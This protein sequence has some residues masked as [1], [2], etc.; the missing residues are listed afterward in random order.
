M[1]DDRNDKI[2]YPLL[3]KYLAGEST[4]EEAIAVDHWILHSENNR[5]VFEQVS[6]AWQ[7]NARQ[8]ETGRS[9]TPTG[10]LIIL[11]RLYRARTHLGVRVGIAASLL[12]LCGA[13]WL[14]VRSPQTRPS[15]TN[16]ANTISYITKRAGK[17]ILRDTLPDGSVVV[18]NTNSILQYSSDFNS[19]NRTLQLDGEAWFDVASKPAQPFRLQ[20]GR[21]RVT[22]L[23]TSFSVQQSA[24][25]VEV[26]VK[27][28]SVLLS[29][30]ADSLIV[31]TGHKGIYD[32]IANKFILLNSFNSND[33]GYATRVFMFENST[34]GDIAAQIDKAY[35]VKVVF[36]DEK[37]KGLTMSSSFDN[38]SITYIFDVISITLHV[39]YKIENNVVYI[40][41]DDPGHRR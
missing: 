34:L 36:R 27:T 17:D 33:Q 18:Q 6:A 4:P 13:L 1:N 38:N 15:A 19:R 28:G 2:D 32:R 37:L 10:R 24:A 29:D 7:G 8:G 12:I 26:A 5:R 39:N 30:D 9:G 25:T 23:G 3:A 40:S 20:I 35:G 16:T 21:L 31:K 14:L 22:V 41:P 11:R